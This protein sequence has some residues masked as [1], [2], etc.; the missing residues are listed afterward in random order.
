[1][2]KRDVYIEKMKTQLDELN[3]KMN[4]LETRAQDAKDDVSEKYQEEMNRLSK[5]SKLSVAKL[6]GI[7]SVGEDKWEGMVAEME[8]VR[9][10]FK[11]SFRY[12]KSQLRS[13]RATEVVPINWTVL[14][15]NFRPDLSHVIS[16][17]IRRQPCPEFGPGLHTGI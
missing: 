12:F 13:L 3:V 7:Q 1:M 17:L 4:K 15:V 2:S 9:D 5:Q 10:A 16:K 8:S 6:E 14:S 11:N